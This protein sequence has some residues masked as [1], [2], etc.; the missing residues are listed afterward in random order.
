MPA[1]VRAEQFAR[2]VG[3]DPDP[4]ARVSDA[5]RQSNDANELCQLLAS[6]L[7]R[8]AIKML[9]LEFPTWGI[10]LDILPVAAQAICSERTERQSLPQL[11]GMG[12]L[13]AGAILI[14]K[15]LSGRQ[16]SGNLAA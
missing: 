5:L 10:V 4:V 9:A 3:R 7:G 12:A 14:F 1:I 13:A 6:P 16:P 15:A 8:V 2:F 11:I